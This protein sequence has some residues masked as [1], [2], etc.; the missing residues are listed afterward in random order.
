M[1]HQGAG[2]QSLKWIEVSECGVL[3]E[4]GFYPIH[5]HLLGNSARG[6]IIEGV[7]VDQGRFRAFV[8]HGSHGVTLRGCAA[9]NSQLTP[10][11][12]DP[13]DG[14]SSNDTLFDHCLALGVTNGG[15]TAVDHG[16]L[17]TAGFWLPRGQGNA[18]VDSV[19]VGARSR[20]QSSGFHWPESGSGRWVFRRNLAH[21]NYAIG[22]YSWGGAPVV[23]EDSNTYHC[24]IAGVD[25]GSYQN[26]SSYR[27]V[28]STGDGRGQN[29]HGGGLGTSLRIHAKANTTES[30]FEGFR[31]DQ[32][33]IRESPYRGTKS[34]IVRASTFAGVTVDAAST[35]IFYRFEDCNLSPKAFT[36]IALGG[37]SILEIYERGALL[38]RWSAGVWS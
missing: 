16:G 25:H 29:P 26:D 30:L 33:N 8:P 13:K 11:W 20:H 38:N 36:L 31:G 21:N 15:S 9:V 35:D 2:P 22:I 18:I 34:S 7:V 5:F 14:D 23:V 19:A 28:S 10:Y 24:G 6:S 32:L 12:W 17:R 37:A 3:G 1:F 27:N 4:L